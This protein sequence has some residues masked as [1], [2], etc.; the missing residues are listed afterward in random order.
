MTSLYHNK[1]ALALR[2]KIAEDVI[3][4]HMPVS[5]EV[6]GRQL[7]EE[8]DTYAR[9]ERLGYYPPLS[10]FEEYGGIDAELLETARNVAWLAAQLVREEVRTRLRTVFSSIRIEAVQSVA[11]SMPTIRPSQP[12]ALI[13]LARH[14]TPDEIRLDIVAT[15]IQKREPGENLERFARNVVHRWLSKSF[16]A[17]EVT[18]ARIVASTVP[19]GESGS[20]PLRLKGRQ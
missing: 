14:C 6:I 1:V 12:N 8:V 5:V 10:F 13:N 4:Q 20:G 17:V 15:L 16:D 2:V 19:G 7:C 3:E 18:S 11:F 9:R